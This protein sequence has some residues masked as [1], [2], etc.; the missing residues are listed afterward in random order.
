M[1]QAFFFQT[2]LY[3]TEKAQMSVTRA[4]NQQEIDIINYDWLIDWLIDWL[5]ERLQ[6]VR[7]IRRLC[8]L[9]LSVSHRLVFTSDR[10][11][12]GVVSG[13]VRA[14]MTLWKSNIGV[15][16]GVISA[17]ES[18][19]EESERFHF[20]PT[21]LT[22][23]SLTFRLWSSE[24]QIVGV[25]S[26]SGRISQSECKFPRFVIGLVLLRLWLRR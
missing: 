7:V 2:P 22:T 23:P 26:R 21:P 5:T 18:E 14:L 25:G 9:Y 20:L 8:Y 10:V 4:R 15:V 11:G 19:S 24:N 1:Y 12:V 17:T 16:S 13:V 6:K 3:K